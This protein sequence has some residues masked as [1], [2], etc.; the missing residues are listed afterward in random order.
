M[1]VGWPMIGIE[2]IGAVPRSAIR[3]AVAVQAASAT[4]TSDRARYSKSSSSMASST[5]E[6][7]EPKVAAMPAAAPA[8]SST[9]RSSAVVLSTW[10]SSEPR[11]PPVAMMGPS[12]PNGPPVP[13]AMADEIGLKKVT[14]GETLLS[15]Y[16]TR[17]MASGIPWPRIAAEP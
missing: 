17:S 5:A 16:S 3:T 9:L 1:P 13:M 4:G 14:A 8:A 12:A 10:P 2:K 11:A 7:G 6:T 15:P